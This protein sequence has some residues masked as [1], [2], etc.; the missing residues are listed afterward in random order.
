MSSLETTE[1]PAVGLLPAEPTGFKIN[2]S[3][4]TSCRAPDALSPPRG[5]C[6]EAAPHS[7][8]SQLGLGSPCSFPLLKGSSLHTAIL[9][10]EGAW[11]TAQLFQVLPRKKGDLGKGQASQAQNCQTKAFNK[12]VP[13]K[14]WD[15]QLKKY[16]Q[17]WDFNNSLGF[18]LFP[19][20]ALIS[21]LFKPGK[22]TFCLL[23]L[24]CSIPHLPSDFEM[25]ERALWSKCYRNCNVWQLWV[26]PCSGSRCDLHAPRL[27]EKGIVSP[28]SVTPLETKHNW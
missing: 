4:C 17:S 1:F 18:S 12:S 7:T 11:A 13:R 2:T 24:W 16:I 14:S 5:Q 19:F 3:F 15:W 20:C 8:C 22:R 25:M 21:F 28:N 23:L 6:R 27:A 9:D 26:H 10:Y